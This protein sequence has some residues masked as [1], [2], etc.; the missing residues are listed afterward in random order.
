MFSFFTNL[1]TTWLCVDFYRLPLCGETG[2]QVGQE[3]EAP[4]PLR[5]MPTTGLLT[6]WTRSGRGCSEP[7]R[8]S[9]MAPCS[10]SAH[11]DPRLLPTSTAPTSAC[12]SISCLF[13]KSLLLLQ[14]PASPCDPPPPRADSLSQALLPHGPEDEVHTWAHSPAGQ[15]PS[16][17]PGASGFGS[18]RGPTTLFVKLR[19]CKANC[20]AWGSALPLTGRPRALPARHG[21]WQQADAPGDLSGEDAPRRGSVGLAL[22]K[23][24]YSDCVHK[25]GTLL[26]DGSHEHVIKPRGP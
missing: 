10:L 26:R 2:N 18:C 9:L 14:S 21:T 13:S 1:I 19:L 12:T 3:E 8:G 5:L 4:W 24:L 17:L 22:L 20:S 23:T 25:E 11:T 6:G 7:P 16:P 15:L